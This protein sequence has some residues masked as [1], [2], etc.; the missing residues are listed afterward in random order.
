MGRHWTD[1]A[2]SKDWVSRACVRMCDSSLLKGYCPSHGW[3]DVSPVEL[4]LM[5][6]PPR[7]TESSLCFQ[8]PTLWPYLTVA[9]TTQYEHRGNSTSV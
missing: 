4:T 5:S 1:V 3:L 9:R 6:L 8:P 7:M 2:M